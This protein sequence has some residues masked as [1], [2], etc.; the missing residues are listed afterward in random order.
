[1][2][3]CY[4]FAWFTLL[5]DEFMQLGK[6]I[7]GGAGFVSNFILWSESGYF[8]NS[9]E[10]KPLLHLWSL[11]IEEQFYIF[12]P[13]LLWVAYK[14]RLNY[15]KL[16]FV[17]FVISFLINISNLQSNPIGTFYS[18]MSRIWELLM[19]SLLAYFCV[20]KNF[21]AYKNNYLSLLSLSLLFL[22]L[23]LLSKHN[24]FPGGGHYCQL[25]PQYY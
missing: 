9:A 2:V 16:I 25:F 7:A 23:F 4:A 18:P 21:S 10:L 11:G 22:G 24:S 6:H 13:F 20:F 1:M 12:W 17:T 15:L 8:D 5:S 19:G 14:I 3:S